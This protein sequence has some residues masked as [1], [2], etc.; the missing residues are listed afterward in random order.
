MQQTVAQLSDQF[1]R[2]ARML[3]QVIASGRPGVTISADTLATYA[4]E[5]EQLREQRAQLRTMMATLRVQIEQ[6]DAS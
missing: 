3:D 4:A 2:L 1:D 5:L 6:H